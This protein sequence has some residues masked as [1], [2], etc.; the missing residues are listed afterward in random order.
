[1]RAFEATKLW[2]TH[3]FSRNSY[4]PNSLMSR[5]C[6]VKHLCCQTSML[7]D[8]ATTFSIVG[9]WIPKLPLIKNH[10]TVEHISILDTSGYHALPNQSAVSLT[11]RAC[12]FDTTKCA[13]AWE[14]VHQRNS[15]SAVVKPLETNEGKQRPPNKHMS[16]MDVHGP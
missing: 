7:Q 15:L 9:S 16:S 13:K 14:F 8:L 11:V 5:I 1:M 4:P 3:S 12:H 6:S 2:K 10:V